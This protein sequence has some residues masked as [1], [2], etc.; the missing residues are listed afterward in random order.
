MFKCLQAHTKGP[1]E[2]LPSQP[3]PEMNSKKLPPHTAALPPLFSPASQAVNA[4]GGRNTTVGTFLQN[5]FSTAAGPQNAQSLFQVS[6][7]GNAR[8]S[9]GLLTKLSLWLELLTFAAASFHA[10]RRKA[11]VHRGEAAITHCG[12]VE[13]LL[14]ARPHH[15]CKVF[16]PSTHVPPPTTS[17]PTERE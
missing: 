17:M 10:L 4:A 11:H 2:Q 15:F 6:L 13:R 3:I 1:K 16:L 8:S 12:N 7:R 9:Q 5:L 14:Q